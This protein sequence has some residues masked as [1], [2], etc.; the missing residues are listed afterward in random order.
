MDQHVTGSYIRL[1]LS[2]P[3]LMDDSEACPR[4]KC[5]RRP[6]VCYYSLATAILD[7][8][9]AQLYHLTRPFRIDDG[10]ASLVKAFES[11][12]GRDKDRCA[13]TR[14]LFLSSVGTL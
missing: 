8:I 11:A 7:D 4:K 5:T 14:D 3:L 1:P 12:T 9:D 2:R 10:Q 13:V 6:M